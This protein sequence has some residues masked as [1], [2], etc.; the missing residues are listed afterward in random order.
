VPY[1]KD[2]TGRGIPV[3]YF[4]CFFTQQYRV[5]V[6]GITEHVEGDSGDIADHCGIFCPTGIRDTAIQCG[7]TISA[8]PF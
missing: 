7:D 6:I 8:S 1:N 2:F 3:V 5:Q 4:I